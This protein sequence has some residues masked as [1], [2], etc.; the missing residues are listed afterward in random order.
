[1]FEILNKKIAGF[2]LLI[3]II[4]IALLWLTA[5]TANSFAP[6][7]HPQEVLVIIASDTD[8]TESDDDDDEWEA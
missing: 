5:K 3:L 4:S 7:N 1:M 2:G 8:S 6:N